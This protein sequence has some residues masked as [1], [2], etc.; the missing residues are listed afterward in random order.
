M[1]MLKALPERY[2]WK[3]INT[4]EFRKIAEE[5]TGQS[6]QG[7]LR[8]VDRIERRAGIQDGVHG[9]PHAEGF[10]RDG[11]DLAGSGHV[12]HAGEAAR[13]DRRQSGGEDDRGGGHVFGVRHG[14]VRQAERRCRSIPRNKCCA[15]T[16]PCAWRWRSGAAS[17][18]RKWASSRSVEGISEGARREAQQFA[19][20]LSRRASCSSCRTIISPPPTDSAKC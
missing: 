15:S 12:P 7:F 9:L 18:S 14:D 10:S 8:A 1:K 16:M 13:R 4:D 20:A 6:L 2:A 11:Q 3:S 17:S 5:F 19:G